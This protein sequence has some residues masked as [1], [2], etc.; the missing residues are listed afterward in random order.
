MDPRITPNGEWDDD[1]DE[2]PD[3]AIFLEDADLFD[4][5]MDPRDEHALWEIWGGSE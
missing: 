1:E 5:S 2:I 3:D 4:P